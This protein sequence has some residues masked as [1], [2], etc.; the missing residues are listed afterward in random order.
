M[1]ATGDGR[2][3]TLTPKGQA[4]RERIIGAA[5][6]LIHAQG[7]HNTN[8]EQI[9]AAAEVSGSQLTRH[10]PTKESLLGAVL[11]WQAGRILTDPRIPQG[12]LDSLAALRHWADAFV[13]ATETVHGGCTFG[14]LAAE[15]IKAQPSQ[16]EAIARGFEQWRQL[17]LDGLTAMRDRGELRADADPVALSHL[18]TA[19]FQGGMLLDQASEATTPLRDALYSALAYVESFAPQR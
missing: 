7:L 9:R 11:E 10:F 1:T 12:R 8:N 14:S 18:L 3:R 4:T 2:P 15:A 17:F 16:R 6:D 19:A 13:T 5:A